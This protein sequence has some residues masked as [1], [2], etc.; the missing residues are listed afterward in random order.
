MAIKKS[1]NLAQKILLPEK[2]QF[3]SSFYPI[4]QHEIWTLYS[5]SS[6]VQW[7]PCYATPGT[8]T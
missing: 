3:T 8:A 2:T 5:Q 1:E 7:Y 4:N 6:E